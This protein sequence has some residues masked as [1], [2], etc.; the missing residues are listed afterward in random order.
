MARI[1]KGQ[2]ISLR[3]YSRDHDHNEVTQ[4]GH[5]IIIYISLGLYSLS[6]RVSYRKI[7]WSL[8]AA[9]FGFRLTIALQIDGYLRN[10][11]AEMP[12][13]FQSDTI[14]IIPNLG[15]SRLHE[16]WR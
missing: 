7:S 11:A 5:G 10:S 9:R 1:I 16:L 15:A 4:S 2:Q 3:D 8:E 12:V 6:R 14:I 13:K